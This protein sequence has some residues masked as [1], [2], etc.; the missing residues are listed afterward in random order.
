MPFWNPAGF[1]ARAGIRAPPP[2]ESVSSLVI[3]EQRGLGTSPIRRAMLRPETAVVSLPTQLLGACHV[4]VLR[5]RPEDRGN[6]CR[7][8]G[9]VR[10]SGRL[11]LTG[12]Q[13]ADRESRDQRGQHE[14]AK[15]WN[16][17]AG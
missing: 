10:T 17:A 9:R 13:P 16:P 7:D 6:R 12:T 5:A 11:R 14:H 1:L 8:G 4:N 2:V 3:P 15:R